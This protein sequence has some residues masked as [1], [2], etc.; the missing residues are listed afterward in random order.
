M[1]NGVKQPAQSKRLAPRMR[2]NTSNG[3]RIL[4][5]CSEPA[6]SGVEGRTEWVHR[7]HGIRSHTPFARPP[8]DSAWMET[9]G[10]GM[11]GPF[12]V[13]TGKDSLAWGP[14]RHGSRYRSHG[15]RPP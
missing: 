6:P 3:A 10:N 11:V 2:E 13:E 15:A 7:R 5:C 12:E 4:H 8:G 9:C 14:G 1:L